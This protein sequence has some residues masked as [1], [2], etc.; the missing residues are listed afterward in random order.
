MLRPCAD[1]LF[2]TW[3]NYGNAYVS[4]YM[5][6]CLS[7]AAKIQLWVE[8][9]SNDHTAPH[10]GTYQQGLRFFPSLKNVIEFG[11]QGGFTFKLKMTIKKLFCLNL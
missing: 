8:Y 6:F 1:N 7:K 5:S 4:V 10:V 9:L 2:N 3:F 11:A